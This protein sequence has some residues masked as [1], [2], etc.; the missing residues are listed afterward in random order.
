M[1]FK[2]KV[3]EE[4]VMTGGITGGALAGLFILLFEALASYGVYITPELQNLV[5]AVVA[6]LFPIVAAWI[7]RRYATSL[8]NPRDN[9]GNPLKADQVMVP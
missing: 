4:P 3:A 7:A 8:A 5:S 1:T 9:D 2:R 6:L